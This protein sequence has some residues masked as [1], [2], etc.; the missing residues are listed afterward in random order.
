MSRRLAQEVAASSTASRGRPRQRRSRR[1]PSPFGLCCA[2]HVWAGGLDRC[3]SG[4]NRSLRTLVTVK[5]ASRRAARGS[6]AVWQ[7]PVNHGQRVASAMR[8]TSARPAVS[9]RV[10][11][12]NRTTPPG[13]RTRRSSASAATRSGSEHI[14][15]H[16]TAASTL[17][18]GSGND[19]ARP[20]R[21]LTGSVAARAAWTARPRRWGSGSA[22]WLTEQR[23]DAAHALFA[24]R[25]DRELE[26]FV[27]VA[28]YMLARLDGR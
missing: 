20:A 25:P 5:P 22:R 15:R 12:R 28:E 14:T 21:T 7:P 17:A 16:S 4:G 13:R 24:D 11:S 3:P 19:S 23:A 10:C 6:R 1:S 26:A 8:C 18:S 2:E 9:A 27:A